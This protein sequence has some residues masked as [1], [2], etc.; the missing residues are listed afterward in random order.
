[1]R[2][3]PRVRAVLVAE[4]TADGIVYPGSTVA[5][6]D[7]LVAG[8]RPD[9][10]VVIGVV[11]PNQPR[12]PGHTYRVEDFDVLVPLPAD[13]ARPVYDSRKVSPHLDAFVGALDELIPDG[14]TI[15]AGIG[16]VPDVAL[17]K[18]TH[19]RDLG[20]HTEVFAKG[21]VDLIESGAVSNASKTN[22]P[23]VTV[24][25]ICLPET[26]GYV[27]ENPAVRLERSAL[28][29]DPREIA[30]NR[31]MRCVN[32]ALQVDLFGQGN[33]EMIDGVQYSGVGGQLDFLRGCGLADDA[34]SILALE[35]TTAGGAVSRIVPRVEPNAVTGTRYDTQVVVTEFGIA[36]LRDASMR[37]K[38]ERLI[39]IAHPDH[40]ERLR[41]EAKR[42]GLL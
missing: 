28:V 31:S 9:D 32:A 13:A 33:A 38:A 2:W 11:D 16:A 15:Q 12:V 3:E 20:I 10:A 4:P 6:D 14:S 37:Q 5:A 1:R 8:S 27:H 25:T 29:L 24:C 7:E 21:F 19:K 39:A 30:K 34:L 22:F 41:D 42:S 40:R 18:L 35:S 23:G 26:Y 17:A 36:W